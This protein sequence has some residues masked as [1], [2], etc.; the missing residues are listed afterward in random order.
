MKGVVFNLLESFVVERFG[1][2][3]LEQ[4]LDEC[5]FETSEP[6]VGPGTYPDT[7]L[8]TFASTAARHA[9]LDLETAEREFG[10]FC[11]PRLLALHGDFA[12]YQDSRSLLRELDS[13]VHVEVR[14]LMRG[15]R[16]PQ[17]TVRDTGP[18]ALSLEYRSTRRMCAFL[19]GLL[20]G[21]AEHF[22]ETLSV[23]HERCLRRGDRSCLLHLE[24]Q[25]ARRVA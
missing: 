4:I 1:H 24:L 6:F 2:E 7:D 17:F 11:F 23:R 3:A 13:V 20:A 15:A 19:E 8:L 22:H 25:P 10:R 14:K 18:N 16:T 12:R 5:R 9:G 21:M